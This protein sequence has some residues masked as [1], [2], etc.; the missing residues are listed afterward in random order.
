MLT[1]FVVR[2]SYKNSSVRVRCH[3]S[4]AEAIEDAKTLS[5]INENVVVVESRF[6]DEKRLDQDFA[7][8]RHIRWAS[9]FDEV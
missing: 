1:K 7:I 8:D 2:I 9:Y 5:K 6:A 3:D 4:V